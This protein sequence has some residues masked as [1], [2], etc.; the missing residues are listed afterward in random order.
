MS[1]VFLLQ[2]RDLVYDNAKYPARKLSYEINV[3]NGV[4]LLHSM[5]D[6]AFSVGQGL[7]R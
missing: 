7:S 6:G 4:F 2:L 1:A 5:R 3:L